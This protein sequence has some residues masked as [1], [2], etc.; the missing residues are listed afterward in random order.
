MTKAM[1]L[2][3]TVGVSIACTTPEIS[4]QGEYRDDSAHYRIGAPGDGWQPLSVPTANAAWIRRGGSS[5]LLVNSQCDKSDAPLSAL[6]GELM[7]GTTERVIVEQRLLPMDG[8]E[9]LETTAEA[10]LDGVLR[11]RQ[12]LVLK[13]DGC[14]F[15]IVLDAP[16]D[17]FDAALGGYHGVVNGFGAMA[18][19]R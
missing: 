12:M 14:V 9:A 10:K 13:K 16:L 18:R 8:R 19:P 7:F 3:A 6:A 15:D 17:E 1:W 11:K 2:A 4:A 5:T